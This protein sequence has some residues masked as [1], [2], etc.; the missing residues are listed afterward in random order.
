MSLPGDDK[1]G[2]LDDV[3]QDCDDKAGDGDDASRNF[4][5]MVVVPLPPVM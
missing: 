4:D 1:A 2:I 5:G 3:F